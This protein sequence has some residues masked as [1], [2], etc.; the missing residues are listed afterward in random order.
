MLINMFKNKIKILLVLI[1]SFLIAN[2]VIT[3][4]FIA[5]TPKINPFFAQNLVAKM[6]NIL[7]KFNQKQQ[8]PQL[9]SQSNQLLLTPAIFNKSGTTQQET[10]PQEVNNVINNSMKKVTTG[11]Y[12]GERD[13]TEV[14]QVKTNEI[15]YNEYTIN[16]NGKEVKVR[17]PEGEKLPGQ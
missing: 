7:P 15:S 12:A 13:G 4:V 5:G 3:S 17:V 2:L 10:I 1:F 11:V 16:I 14:Y 9:A 8:S 6:N